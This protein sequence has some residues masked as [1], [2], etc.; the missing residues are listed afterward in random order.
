MADIL[1]FKPR[2]AATLDGK[3]GSLCR[4]GHHSWKVET[5]S[6]FDVKQGKLV[7]VYCC[8]RCGKKKITA[9]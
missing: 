4:E 7:T 5:K 6:R 1:Q 9:H 8:K 3:G 2:K